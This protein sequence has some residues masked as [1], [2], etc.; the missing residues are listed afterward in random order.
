M[1]D[2]AVLVLDL[3]IKTARKAPRQASSSQL[4]LQ[5]LWFLQAD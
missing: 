3:A 2:Y 5:L 4:L 1:L